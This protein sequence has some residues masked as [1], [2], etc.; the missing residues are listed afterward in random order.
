MH[1]GDKSMPRKH[2]HLYLSQLLSDPPDKAP[3]EESMSASEVP[4]S[5]LIR[6]EVDRLPSPLRQVITARFGFDG[7]PEQT[8]EEIANSLRITRQ[9]VWDRQ[10]RALRYLRDNLRGRLAPYLDDA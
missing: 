7:H 1:V 6:E 8:F 3:R 9:A 10:K 2:A 5:D 4:Y